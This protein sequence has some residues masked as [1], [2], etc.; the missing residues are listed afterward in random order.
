[1]HP[2]TPPEKMQY[3]KLMAMKKRE[4]QHHLNALIK[5]GEPRMLVNSMRDIVLRQKEE[6]RRKRIHLT[7]SGRLWDEVIKPLQAERRSMRGCLTYKAD[8]ADDPRVFAYRAYQVV[9]DE[10]MRRLKALKQEGEFT[11]S[12]FAKL[13]NYPN[14]GLH[15][16][17]FVPM[18]IKL[19]ITALF[20]AI[21][22]KAKAKRKHPFE[23]IVTED[24]HARR[25]HKLIERT[26][27]ELLRASQDNALTPSDEAQERV[28]TIRQA[29]K[30]IEQLN[31][32]E[33]VPTTWHGLL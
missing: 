31:P 2:E 12:T 26:T 27:K 1:M 4:L 13:K 24:I 21:P 11:P 33:P 28:N 16:T 30:R 29:L 6:L 19:R 22:Y 9:I 25:K 3:P 32:N 17:D 5:K 23:R 15:W 8:D 10:L 18:K 7:T 14:N 20:D